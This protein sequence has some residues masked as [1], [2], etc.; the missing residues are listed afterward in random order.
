MDYATANSYDWVLTL[1]QDSIP[2]EDLMSKY[3]DFATSHNGVGALTCN[4]YDINYQTDFQD[5]VSEPQNVNEC[6][7]SGCLMNVKA[8]QHTS[9]YNPDLFIDFVDFDICYKLIESGYSVIKIPY[10]G[11]LHEYG[12]G[13][14]VRFLWK[15]V[16]V[17]NH[18]SWRKYYMAR[19]YII[20]SRNHRR[21]I[22][23][24]KCL[25]YEVTLLAKSLL[26]EKD[27][28]KSI[29]YILKGIREAV[30]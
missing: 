9:G 16:L 12:H 11:L 28:R 2:R 15:K 4:L 25:K 27:K 29:G 17:T 1:D 14:E 19:N 30:K 18:V 22:S 24:G 23:I 10:Y 21:Y 8:Y 20:V 6:I 3:M 13:R 26:Y 5:T 7:T